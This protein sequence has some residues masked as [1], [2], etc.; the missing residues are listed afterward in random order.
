MEWVT[1]APQIASLSVK[2]KYRKWFSK[3]PFTHWL[4]R[5]QFPF[6]CEIQNI[7]S[8]MVYVSQMNKEYV[9]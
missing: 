9:L 2:V 1:K 7:C 8:V 5:L 6:S 4:L 3:L